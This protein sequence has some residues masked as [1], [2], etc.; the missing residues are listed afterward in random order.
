MGQKSVRRDPGA[1]PSGEC[2]DFDAVTVGL[3]VVL[4]GF[5]LRASWARIERS[6]VLASIEVVALASGCVVAA[7]SAIDL[8]ND[9]ERPYELEQL[10]RR[11]AAAA[12][13]P[14]EEAIRAVIALRAGLLD[15]SLAVDTSSPLEA[16]RRAAAELGLPAPMPARPEMGTAVPLV[17]QGQSGNALPL[18]GVERDAQ[19][20]PPKG[21]QRRL[22]IRAFREWR[23]SLPPGALTF[24]SGRHRPDTYAGILKARDLHPYPWPAKLEPL[25]QR[26]LHDVL[27][28]ASGR[29][30]VRSIP[31]MLQQQGTPIPR[32]GLY[33][34][35]A[36]L[37]VDSTWDA[38][39]RVLWV[40]PA[41]HDPARCDACW[42]RH[43]DAAAA[44][45]PRVPQK[46][47]SG[48]PR[49]AQRVQ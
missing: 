43:G 16:A 44:G 37:D 29:A 9:V 40:L 32:R 25:Y 8:G 47:R 24:P 46:R 18:P 4:E 49:P 45:E 7:G 21:G 22:K 42:R 14:A 11:I 13:V 26:L 27:V 33:R 20:R 35:A 48:S 2:A 12:G 30:P 31:T 15:D 10:G 1:P 39:G 38:D 3:V 17:G 6:R 23:R 41:E 19:P 28:D 5:L 36:D 34:A